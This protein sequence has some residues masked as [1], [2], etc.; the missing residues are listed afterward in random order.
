MHRAAVEL[1]DSGAADYW[2]VG[3]A[4]VPG[5]WF[6]SGPTLWERIFG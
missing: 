4:V 1:K 3:D 6:T 5:S 2:M